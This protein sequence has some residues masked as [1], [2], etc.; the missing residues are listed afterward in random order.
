MS[1]VDIATLI[2][3]IGAI[4]LIVWSIAMGGGSLIVF[5]NVPSIVVVL[6]G[7]AFMLTVVKKIGEVKTGGND[8]PQ[9]PV[10]INSAKVVE[11]SK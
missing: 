2:G 5:F 11:K 6:G 10:T 3:V 9:Q 7:V 4:A 1:I 8:K